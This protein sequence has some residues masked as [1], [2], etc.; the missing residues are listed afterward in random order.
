M[1]SLI[2]G[3]GKV[4]TGLFGMNFGREFAKAFFEPDPKRI[5]RS[6]HHLGTVTALAFGG[7]GV[8]FVCSGG[9]LVGLSG[10]SGAAPT[11]AVLR[12]EP[13]PFANG[14]V[15]SI[16]SMSSTSP[17]RRKSISTIPA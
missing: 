11:P 1:R 4:L 12:L 16:G 13:V 7:A 17:G 5:V 6:V 9:E 10:H 8:R 15:N 3:A 2:F 14:E